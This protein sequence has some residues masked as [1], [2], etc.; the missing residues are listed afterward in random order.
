MML[1]WCVFNLLQIPSYGVGAS[2]RYA[3]VRSKVD[4]SDPNPAHK[5]QHSIED[6]IVDS[7]QGREINPRFSTS[8]FARRERPISRPNFSRGRTIDLGDRFPHSSSPTGYRYKRAASMDSPL[9]P[10]QSEAPSTFPLRNAK[11]TRMDRVA[12][13]ES[14]SPDIFEESE[15]DELLSGPKVSSELEQKERE[16][17][18]F[19]ALMEEEE[20]EEEEGG[21]SKGICGM[22][23]TSSGSE[24]TVV[25]KHILS[26]ASKNASADMTIIEEDELEEE[27]KYFESEESPLSPASTSGGFQLPHPIPRLIITSETGEL[28]E[29]VVE[30]TRSFSMDQED[31]VLSTAL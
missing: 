17:T 16:S 4:H 21:E 1:D 18:A 10:I 29:T 24:T 6:L 22:E 15:E 27:Q 19:A 20:E 30:K 9:G 25:L 23:V 12:E 13:R 5:L 2:K 11:L 26:L 7:K 31:T 3:N 8:R 14:R 28:V